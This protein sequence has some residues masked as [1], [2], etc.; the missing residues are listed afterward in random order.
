MT[1]DAR[2]PDLGGPGRGAPAR[3]EGH[4]RRLPA[5]GI[6]HHGQRPADRR[7]GRGR[8]S[9]KIK[10]I[11]AAGIDLTP[12][13]E[14]GAARP[15]PGDRRLRQPDGALPGVSGARTGRRA[16]S[17]PPAWSRP[18][19]APSGSGLPTTAARSSRS[20]TA[21]SPTCC[22]GQDCMAT[23]KLWDVMR[24][25]SAPYGT[26]RPGELRDQ[27]GRQRALGPEGQAA[28]AAGLRA[29]RRAAEGEHPLLRQQHRPLLRH[30][31]QH[32]LV[33]RA[34]LQGGQALPA[35][36]ARGRHRG[37]PPERGAGRAHARADRP[38]RRADGRRLDVAQRR[39]RRAAERG[40]APVPRSSGSRTTSCRRT[41]RATSAC[42]SG[43]RA[44]P[45]RP[46][47]TG[48]PIHPFALA[49]SRGLVDILQPDLAWVRRHHRRPCGSATWPRRTA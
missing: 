19:T 40:A 48:T 36:G 43:C 39:V 47:S 10:E 44:R 41:W 45:W 26:R 17:G 14:D 46:A 2:A 22:A 25:I 21:T 16:G 12:R 15:A 13:A 38:G 18:R 34:R 35:R 27:R 20:S 6:P 37:H 23:E 28:R 49:A 9:V 32:R 29:A 30:R 3:V 33:P 8:S 7:R 24:R 31:A 42:A 11:R 5:T 1:D 4:H